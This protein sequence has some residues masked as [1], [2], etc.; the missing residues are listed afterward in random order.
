MCCCVDGVCP[1]HGGEGLVQVAVVRLDDPQ[2]RQGRLVAGR[3]VLL[4]L[5]RPHAL[6]Q[7]LQ[8]AF[9]GLTPGGEVGVCPPQGCGDN[10][11]QLRLALDV[12]QDLACQGLHPRRKGVHALCQDL[13][14]PLQGQAQPAEKCGAFCLP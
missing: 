10:R 13:T 12:L 9:Q 7:R 8:S 1:S 4:V 5:G 6:H 11:I 2:L 3:K 14:L